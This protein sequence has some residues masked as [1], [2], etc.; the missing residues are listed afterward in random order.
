[1]FKEGKGAIKWARLSCYSFAANAVHLKIHARVIG[2][3]A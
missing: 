3:K 2:A 1:M